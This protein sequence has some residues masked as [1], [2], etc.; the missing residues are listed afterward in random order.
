MNRKRRFVVLATVCI[1]LFSLALVVLAQTGPPPSASGTG[2]FKN[3]VITFGAAE[4]LGDDQN[5]LVTGLAQ[6][7]DTQLGTKITIDIDCLRLPGVGRADDGYQYIARN[8]VFL[9]FDKC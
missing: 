8:V 6:Q 9:E 4:H 3:S 2:Q 5:P 7:H 1:G